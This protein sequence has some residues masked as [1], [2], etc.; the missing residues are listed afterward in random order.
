MEKLI[1]EMDKIANKT[2]FEDLQQGFSGIFNTLANS[3]NVPYYLY[4]IIFY[5]MLN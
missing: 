3:L 4:V 1:S 2:S 5:E